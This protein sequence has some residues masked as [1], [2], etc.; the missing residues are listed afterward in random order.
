MSEYHQ[1]A[2]CSIHSASPPPIH[3]TD[4]S[5][6]VRDGHILARGL[7]ERGSLGHTFLNTLRI[8]SEIFSVVAVDCPWP[9]LDSTEPTILSA[10]SVVRT[11]DLTKGVLLGCSTRSTWSRANGRLGLGRQGLLDQLAGN[12]V[13]KQAHRGEGEWDE[14]NGGDCHPTTLG[15]CDA[16]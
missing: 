11:V 15:S 8:P 3:N 12:S 16:G 13:G 2:Q 4:I 1:C 6:L 7:G 9:V 10:V 14:W 5:R